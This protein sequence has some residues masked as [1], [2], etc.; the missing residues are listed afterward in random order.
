MPV[1][2]HHVQ[3]PYTDIEKLKKMSHRSI[4][5]GTI[6]AAL[7]LYLGLELGIELRVITIAYFPSPTSLA[8]QHTQ[9]L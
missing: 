9:Y 7:T 8:K 6:P 2:Y 5:Y 4:V 3:Y 1:I